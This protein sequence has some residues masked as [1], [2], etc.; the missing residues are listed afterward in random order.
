LQLESHLAIVVVTEP[1]PAFAWSWNYDSLALFSAAVNGA[2]AGPARPVWIAA[3]NMTPDT[4]TADVIEHC[5]AA[6]GVPAAVN[7]IQGRVMISPNDTGQSLRVQNRI[8]EVITDAFM[9]HFM[10]AL[11]AGQV[12]AKLFFLVD[13]VVANAQPTNLPPPPAPYRPVFA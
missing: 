11:P 13:K 12:L 1:D 3:G 5:A 8:G 9:Q 2:A 6:A 7:I 10:A 4:F